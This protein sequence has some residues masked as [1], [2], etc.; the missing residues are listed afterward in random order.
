MPELKNPNHIVSDTEVYV[1]PLDSGR[2]QVVR[3]VGYQQREV[4]PLI[5][6]SDEALPEMDCNIILNE[7]KKPNFIEVDI[8]ENNS[9]IPKNNPELLDGGQVW[10]YKSELGLGIAVI[11][12]D[13]QAFNTIMEVIDP[14]LPKNEDYG[15]VNYMTIQEYPEDT[16]FATHM[17]DA[18]G[19]D[20]GTV[21]FFLNEDFKGGNLL[22]NGHTVMG[23]TGTMVAFN[24]NTRTYHSVEP[25]W[26]GTRYTLC[27]WFGMFETEI[28]D[29]NAPEQS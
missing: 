8:D 25:I 26:G 1:D 11:P 20:T 3:P 6:I 15:G 24:N 10:K 14:F 12:Q 2:I 19:K 23:R 4:A 27:I 16:Y 17:D 28:Q 21:I 22:V 9:V 29:D 13:T 18:D 7:Y 5:M